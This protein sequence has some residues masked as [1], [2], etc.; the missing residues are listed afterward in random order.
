VKVGDRVGDGIVAEI[1]RDAVVM[2]TSTGERKRLSLRPPPA[3][4]GQE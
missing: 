4:A 2:E 3:R 1:R